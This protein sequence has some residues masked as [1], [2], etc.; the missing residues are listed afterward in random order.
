MLRIQGH[1]VISQQ[2]FRR[3]D[4]SALRLLAAAVDD[5]G[6]VFVA[7]STGSRDAD[8]AR[9]LTP[10]LW[11]AKLTGDSACFE[12]RAMVSELQAMRQNVIFVRAG[13]SLSRF[14]VAP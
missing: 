9:T 2:V 3:E 12:L 11:R 10:L 7:T 13:D 1:Q 14:D 5:I 4:Y 8:F 6:N